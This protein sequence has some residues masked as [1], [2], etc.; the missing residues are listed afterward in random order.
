MDGWI[1]IF[2]YI[3]IDVG[4]IGWIYT[5]ICQSI[6]P[7]LHPYTIQ[8]IHPSIFN[9]SINQYIYTSIHSNSHQF[10]RSITHAVCNKVNQLPNQCIYG[11]MKNGQM[12][13]LIYIWRNWQMNWITFFLYIWIDGLMAD[14]LDGWRVGWLV[15]CEVGVV[16]QALHKGWIRLLKPILCNWNFSKMVLDT[17]LSFREN[18]IQKIL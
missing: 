6:H 4:M 9:Q 10:T 2:L 1:D 5:K 12:D 7:S 13:G 15:W 18:H 11:G 8:S 3:W 17:H 16:A 14:W